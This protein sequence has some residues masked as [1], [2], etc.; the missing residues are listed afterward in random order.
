ME[1]VCSSEKSVPTH[2][3]TFCHNTDHNRNNHHHKDHNELM[4]VQ[5]GLQRLKFQLAYHIYLY[6]I[7]TSYTGIFNLVQDVYIAV[8]L[9]IKLIS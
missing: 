8:H 1:A 4:T 6:G 3:T 7:C 2:K 5:M 9:L